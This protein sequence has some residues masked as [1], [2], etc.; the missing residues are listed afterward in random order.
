MVLTVH[1]QQDSQLFYV[2]GEFLRRVI[3]LTLLQY[4]KSYIEL[5]MRPDDPGQVTTDCYCRL[6]LLAG[7]ILVPTGNGATRSH[8]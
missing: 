5:L 6:A 2:L 3:E 7:G 4:N 8:R 1:K